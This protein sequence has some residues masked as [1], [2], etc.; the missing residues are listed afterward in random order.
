MGTQQPEKSTW[1]RSLAGF[2]AVGFGAVVGFFLITEHRAHLYG[3]LPFLLLL[4]C[5][6]MMMFMHHGHG[7]HDHQDHERRDPESPRP[8]RETRP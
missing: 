5:P 2:A 6:V 4:A 7:H 8:A 3:A 1:W